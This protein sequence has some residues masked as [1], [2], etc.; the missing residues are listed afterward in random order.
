MKVRDMNRRQFGN[1]LIQ[2]AAE[3]MAIASGVFTACG[4]I[5]VV[6][7]QVQHLQ[8]NNSDSKQTK[9]N[10]DESNKIYLKFLIGSGAVTA[11]SLKAVH[12]AKKTIEAEQLQPPSHKF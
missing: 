3:K 12:E 2:I 6:K 10:M 4:A 5:G 8:S 11:C 1:F 9:A 7:N